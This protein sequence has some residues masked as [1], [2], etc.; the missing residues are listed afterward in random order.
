MIN[1]AIKGPAAD[2]SAAGDP[3]Y[4]A[5]ATGTQ[6]GGGGTNPGRGFKCSSCRRTL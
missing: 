5:A 1:G 3:A 2:A 4:V 6:I